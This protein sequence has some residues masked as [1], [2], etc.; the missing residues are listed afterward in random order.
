MSKKNLLHFTK[1]DC[2]ETPTELYQELDRI[3]KFDFDPCPLNPTF[4]GLTVEWGS[5]NFVNP[6]YSDIES[7]LE[8]A[9]EQKRRGKSSVFLITARSN[10][11]YWFEFVFPHANK[12]VFL[13][14]GLKFK[15]YKTQFPVPL[16]LVY[17]EGDREKIEEDGEKK[18]LK[19]YYS[20]ENYGQFSDNLQDLFSID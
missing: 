15:G 14:R 18:P 1:N 17:F 13:K 6:P 20:L 2:V 12:I 4:D 5:S 7:F 3:F 8:K 19:K 16:C 10:T 9:V 11:N